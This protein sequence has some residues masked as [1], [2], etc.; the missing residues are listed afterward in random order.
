MDWKAC[1]FSGHRSLSDRHIPYM[2]EYLKTQLAQLCAMGCRTF[3][4]GGAVGFDTIAALEVL[5]LK[6]DFPEVKLHL[7]LPYPGQA[8]HFSASEKSTYEFIK[9]RANS[10]LYLYPAYVP[11]CMYARNRALVEHSELLLCYLIR[12]RSGT[13][14]TVNYARRRGVPVINL[15][16]VI[17]EEEK[18]RMSGPAVIGDPV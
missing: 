12:R 5:K 3:Y 4:A 9:E 13:M 14:Y 2:H 6:A 17:D 8:D 18:K 16:D 7:L 11:E 15:A 1:C 10:F